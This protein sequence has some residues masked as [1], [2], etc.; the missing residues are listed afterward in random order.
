M[1]S[2]VRLEEWTATPRGR[3]ALADGGDL[4]CGPDWDGPPDVE[5]AR[6]AS[7][8]PDMA[9]ALLA[10]EWS[11]LLRIDEAGAFSMGTVIRKQTGDSWMMLACVDL[12]VERGE[13]REVTKGHDVAG[14]HR[15]FVAGGAS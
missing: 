10:L 6:L 9:R 13:L 5:R 7:A 2:S 15:V 12:M 11:N 4:F 3:V 1:R 8:A 14:Q